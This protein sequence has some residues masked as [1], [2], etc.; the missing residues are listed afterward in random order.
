MRAI[1]NRGHVLRG[2][3]LDLTRFCLAR[4]T[5]P[6]AASAFSRFNNGSETWTVNADKSATLL[7]G[8][9]AGPNLR[10][11]VKTAPATPWVWA[12]HLKTLLATSTQRAGLL[13]KNSG[14]NLVHTI[15]LMGDGNVAVERWLNA[16][17]LSATDLAINMT[18]GGD[19]FLAVG[20]DLTN[21]NFY[22]SKGH[23]FDWN[24]IVTVART[25]FL[26]AN[27]WGVFINEGSASYSA[28]ATIFSM[29]PSL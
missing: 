4:S 22:V 5:Y 9:E 16:T 29:K 15:S 23:E 6:L 1:D 25:T 21:R 13:F 10:C 8:A 24:P 2:G 27:Q 3:E 17:T 20:D 18:L 14:A 11:W 12:V 19:V 7:L 26:T 28:L